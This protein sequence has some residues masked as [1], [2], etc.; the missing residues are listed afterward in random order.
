MVARQKGRYELELEDFE[1]NAAHL[2]T[3]ARF[4]DAFFRMLTRQPSAVK[5]RR[6]GP[7]RTRFL[8]EAK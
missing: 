7:D 6:L 5:T 1:M 8:V 4:L 2:A 3:F